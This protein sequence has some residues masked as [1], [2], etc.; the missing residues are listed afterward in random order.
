MHYTLFL[1]TA[2]SQVRALSSPYILALI[3]YIKCWSKQGRSMTSRTRANFTMLR[4]SFT[5]I[6]TSIFDFLFTDTIGSVTDSDWKKGGVYTALVL[7]R[8]Y[9][10]Q[11]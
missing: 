1:Y 3:K 9:S 2:K 6:D 4:S 10:P 8:V 5:F 11:Y 7:T